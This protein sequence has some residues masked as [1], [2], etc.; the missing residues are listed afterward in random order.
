MARLTPLSFLRGLY[1]YCL[2]A[3][4]AFYLIF[5][6][7]VSRQTRR[8][9]KRGLR[10]L[11]GRGGGAPK[12]ALS[13]AAAAAEEKAA[14]LIHARADAALG[15]PLYKHR[16]DEVAPALSGSDADAASASSSSSSPRP[17]SPDACAP[18]SV[19]QCPVVHRAFTARDGTRLSYHILYPGNPR[20]MV[21]APGLGLSSDFAVFSSIIHRYGRI[22]GDY[23]FITSAKTT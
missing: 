8:V 11:R 7:T 9:L 3:L 13:A 20:V 14:R 21:F 6:H 23:S 10:C 15:L 17:A 1:Y 18:W 19:A 2:S 22:G 16:R 5:V 12:T 4:A